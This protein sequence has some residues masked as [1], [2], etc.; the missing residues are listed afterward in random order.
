MTIEIKVGD[1]ADLMDELKDESVDLTVT[2]PPYDNLRNYKGYKFSFEQIARHLFRVTKVGGV[3][4]WVVGDSTV[5]GSETGTSFR[6]ALYFMSLGFNLHDT[7]IYRKVNPPPLEQ[8]RYQPAFEYMLILTHGK[9]QTFHPILVPCKYVGDKRNRATDKK[10]LH[11]TK[12]SRPR[13]KITVTR[14]EKYGHN[15]WDFVVGRDGDTG[16]HS[17]PFPLQLARNHILSWSNKGDTVF[18]PMMGSGTTGKAAT[19]LERNF[20]GYDISAEYVAIAK[21]RIEKAQQEMAQSIKDVSIGA[22]R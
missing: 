9:P 3:L 19:L 8:S 17:A 13:N 12:M 20:I 2:S 16:S 10:P 21:E 5:N 6:Q 4:V 18:D 7:M 1:C 11:E 15:V 14:A 22:I